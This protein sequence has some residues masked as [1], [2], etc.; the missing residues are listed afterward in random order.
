MAIFTVGGIKGGSGKTT[1][2]TNLAV[3]LAA[4]GRDVSWSMLTIRK[5]PAILRSGGIRDRGACRLHGDPAYRRCGRTEVRR[6][7]PSTM[8]L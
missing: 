2:A 7:L 1:V 8:T 3:L 4:D 6:L 5:P